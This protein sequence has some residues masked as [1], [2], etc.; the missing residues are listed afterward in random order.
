MLFCIG[1]IHGHFDKLMA[2]VGHCRAFA[3]AAGVETTSF[4]LLG[5][6]VDRGPA[7]REVLDFLAARPANLRAI[8]GNHEDMMMAALAGGEQLDRW[9]SNGGYETLE[10]YGADDLH[11]VPRDHFDFL[12]A[13]PTFID[14]GQRLFVHAG[15]DPAA[16]E[17]RDRH[18]LLWTR[19]HPPEDQTLS[20]FI[21]HGHTPVRGL[22]ELKRNRL[23]LDTGAGWGRRLSAAAFLP[24]S[25]PPAAFI[26]DMG[27]V[28]RV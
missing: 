20:R 27:H 1:D 3:E 18:T 28:T 19:K 22:P 9:L 21:V 17:A 15:I 26:D 14:D 6:Y 2:L 7:S 11:Q 5:D 10:S 25:T 16:P 12:S 13:L 24:G 8:C 4:I 23:N